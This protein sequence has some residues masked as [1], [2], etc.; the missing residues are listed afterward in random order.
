MPRPMVS[1]GQVSSLVGSRFAPG[2]RASFFTRVAVI[3]GKRNPK[4]RDR[5]AAEK[6]HTEAIPMSIKTDRSPPLDRKMEN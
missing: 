2:R 1:F 3:Y 4:K 6:H 5:I